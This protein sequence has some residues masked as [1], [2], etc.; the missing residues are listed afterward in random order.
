MARRRRVLVVGL[1]ALAGSMS[2]WLVGCSDSNNPNNITGPGPSPSPSAPTAAFTASSTSGVAPLTIQFTST[3]TGSIDGWQWSFGDGSASTLANPSHVYGTLGAYTVSLTVHGSGGSNTEIKSRFALVDEIRVYDSPL[4]LNTVYANRPA[5]N[6]A[7]C[8]FAGH[9]PDVTADIQLV[10]RNSGRELG[11][12]ESLVAKETQADWTLGT[13]SGYQQLLLI[14]AN[15]GYHIKQ[16][17][18]PSS[19]H[20]HYIDTNTTTEYFLGSD[21]ATPF[22]TGD[23]SGN[24]VCNTSASDQTQMTVFLKRYSIRV[25]P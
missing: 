16:I 22:I 7:D 14:G 4:S 13:G 10:V 3:S 1:L 11:V 25:G 21:L 17:Y 5:G 19:M 9:G 20:V 12:L 18:E 24:D 6:T 2:A 8:E 23:T 15:A